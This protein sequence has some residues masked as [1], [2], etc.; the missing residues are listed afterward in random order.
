M[1]L[2]S[3]CSRL[4]GE[5]PKYTAHFHPASKRKIVLYANAMMI[6]VLLWFANGFLLCHEILQTSIGIA[7]MTAVFLAVVIFIIERCIILASGSKLII[8]SRLALGFLIAILGSLCLDEVIFKNDIDIKM[9]E[10]KNSAIEQSGVATNAIHDMEITELEAL[11]LTKRNDWM[12]ALKHA[13]EECDGTGGSKVPRKGP[14]CEMKIELANQIQKDYAHEAG[15][16]AI[17]ISKRD[18]AIELAKT[19]A[20]LS[21]NEHGLLLRIKAM[22]ELVSSN[23]FMLISYIVFTLLIFFLEFL[24]VMI[25]MCS[26]ET[27]DEKLEKARDITMEEKMTALLGRRTQYSQP[28]EILEKVKSANQVL[29]KN[30]SRV[31]N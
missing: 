27:I 18:S 21:F 26:Y 9:A 2:F 30:H 20:A 19:E 16:L 28:Y 24:V 12:E 22:F 6:P 15:K 7:I 29:N 14:I 4:I 1:T 23:T 5:N 8:A 11:V 31:L 17:L 25:K 13:S 3:L 10:Y